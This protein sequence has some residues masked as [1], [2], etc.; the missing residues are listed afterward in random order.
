[1]RIKSPFSRQNILIL[2]P[3]ILVMILDLVFTLLGQPPS[4]W[5]NYNLFNEGSPLGIILL[6]IHPAY[7]I[8][9]FILYLLFVLFLITNLKKPLK[10]IVAL[11]FFLGHIWGSVSWIPVLLYNFSQIQIDGWYLSIGYFIIISIVSG[12]CIN[13]WLKTKNEQQKTNSIIT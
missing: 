9:F 7:L 6:S 10:I 11:S 4:Y 2:S 1:M 3:I 12:F 5:Q 8:L 13:K